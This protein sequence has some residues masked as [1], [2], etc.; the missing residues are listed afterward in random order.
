MMSDVLRTWK[1]VK[2]FWYKRKAEVEMLYRNYRLL[3][4]RT[5]NE[6]PLWRV[7]RNIIII[8]ERI[9]IVECKSAATIQKRVRGMIGRK[10]I[11]Q[12]RIEKAYVLQKRCIAVFKI[13]R[14]YRNWVAKQVRID[15]KEA[16]VK[17]RLKNEYLSF[18]K[19][20]IEKE[21]CKVLKSKVKAAYRYENKSDWTGRKVFKYD[22]RFSKVE[23]SRLTVA[24]SKSLNRWQS[25]RAEEKQLE[26]LN[27]SVRFQFI[28]KKID[29]NKLYE[30][31]YQQ[32]IAERC[33]IR[34]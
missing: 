25:D 9:H 28:N 30:A 23:R 11:R 3:V 4:E 22:Q 8:E 21:R 7:E 5:G 1:G 20:E 26:D 31:Y 10:F 13:Q 14:A 17:Q 12:Y 27:S 18:K 34:K 15:R 2:V 6:P 33:K 29:K 16:K 24:T 32:E 19:K